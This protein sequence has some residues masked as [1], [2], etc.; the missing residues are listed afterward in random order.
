MS[1]PYIEPTQESAIA[2]ISRNISG[3]IFMLNLLRLRATADYRQFP[4]LALGGEIS[5][6]EAFQKYIDHTLPLLR[7]TGGDLVFIGDGGNFFIG[8]QD[9]RW[10]LVMLVRQSSM[11]D[12][13]S[14]AQNPA[15]Q[16]GHGHRIAAIEDSRLLPL[17][18]SAR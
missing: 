9:E 7:R 1:Q 2:L 14:F 4:E 10:D 3:E 16:A 8:P 6:R 13:F 17:T 18:A 15:F 5:G 12:F 11:Q